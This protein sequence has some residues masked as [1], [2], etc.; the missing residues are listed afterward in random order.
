[1]KEITTC[2]QI[3][4]ANNDRLCGGLNCGLWGWAVAG[5]ERNPVEDRRD[6]GENP[7]SES[8]MCVLRSRDIL[9]HSVPTSHGPGYAE[10][11]AMR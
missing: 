2:E 6:H 4:Q 10:G 9:I 11:A 8:P 5:Y 3:T 1:M 7:K